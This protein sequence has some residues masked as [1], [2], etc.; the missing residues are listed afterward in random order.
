MSIE[1]WMH[2]KRTTA[3]QPRPASPDAMDIVYD[4]T[5]NNPYRDNDSMFAPPGASML[6]PPSMTTSK[7]G[8]VSR[9]GFDDVSMMVVPP[10]PPPDVGDGDDSTFFRPAAGDRSLVAGKGVGFAGRTNVSRRLLNLYRNQ[11]SSLMFLLFCVMFL[12]Q[13]I[14]LFLCDRT[15]RDR[16]F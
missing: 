6:E 16:K 7:L 3:S 8:S 14:I 2:K 15:R 5:V 1:E 9:L 13:I 11:F 12:S 4:E 10:P